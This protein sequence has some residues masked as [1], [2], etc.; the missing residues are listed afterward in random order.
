M[1]QKTVIGSAKTSVDCEISMCKD[2]VWKSDESMW[3]LQ[4]ERR[5]LKTFCIG[6][7]HARLSDRLGIQ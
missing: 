4:V 5:E 3:T 2:A 1:L 6:Q 7:G